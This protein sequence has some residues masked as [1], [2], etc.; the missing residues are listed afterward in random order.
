MRQAAGN[1]F[2]MRVMLRMIRG[3]EVAID[4]WAWPAPTQLSLTA[5]D[6]RPATHTGATAT[7]CAIVTQYAIATQYTI[8]TLCAI[9]THP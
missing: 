9:V 8:G 6:S 5:L 3:L 4:D 1:D 2:E 7:H